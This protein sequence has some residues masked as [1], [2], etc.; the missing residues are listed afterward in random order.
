MQ[1]YRL[2]PSYQITLVILDTQG[3]S[4]PDYSNYML[5][6]SGGYSAYNE[7]GL[8]ARTG[9]IRLVRRMPGLPELFEYN[10]KVGCEIELTYI[11][12]AVTRNFGEPN[13]TF[14]PILKVPVIGKGMVVE[15]I[16][17]SEDNEEIILGISDGITL[18]SGATPSGFVTCV[19][20]PTEEVGKIAYIT[21]IINRVGLDRFTTGV[22][23]DVYAVVLPRITGTILNEVST[24]S[25]ALLGQLFF[26]RNRNLYIDS[27]G[28]LNITGVMSNPVEAYTDIQSDK[29]LKFFKLGDNAALPTDYKIE[30]YSCE[31][32]SQP[33]TVNRSSTDG[34][35]TTTSVDEY[36][37]VLRQIKRKSTTRDRSSPYF[38]T[39]YTEVTE[40]YETSDNG[41]IGGNSDCN[42]YDP[43]RLLSRITTVQQPIGIARA[44]FIAAR[45]QAEAD[46]PSLGT[47]VFSPLSTIIQS[48]TTETWVYDYE[49][50]IDESCEELVILSQPIPITT[51]GATQA[52]GGETFKYTRTVQQD[53][54]SIFPQ[55]GNPRL[56]RDGGATFGWSNAF[57]TTEI[58]KETYTKDLDSKDNTWDYIK[59]VLG[60]RILVEPEVV[61]LQAANDGIPLSTVVVNAL[62]L[63]SNGSAS[64]SNTSPNEPGRYPQRKSRECRPKCFTRRT[65]SNR[66]GLRSPKNTKSLSYPE[67][68]TWRNKLQVSD[69]ITHVDRLDNARHHS[70]SLVGSF[71][72]LSDYVEVPGYVFETV[73]PD[74][75]Q[76]QFGHPVKP[77]GT[78]WVRK[79][80]SLYRMYADSINV[81]ISKDEMYW[82]C[83]GLMDSI[84]G[85]PNSSNPIDPGGG[86]NPTLPPGTFR[87]DDITVLQPREGVVIIDILNTNSNVYYTPE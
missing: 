71:D 81:A 20:D 42:L 46:D 82:G 51:V 54:A 79:D 18:C 49:D 14:E 72:A 27:E 21:S 28:K 58:F 87:A 5:S 33:N 43:G 26:M 45:Q 10:F 85:D 30:T 86:G 13:I 36:D 78:L 41:K 24:S 62:Q 64:E 52:A 2:N 12:D 39:N 29:L 67:Y 32:K 19:T 9:E 7:S 63:I 37:D 40:L 55:A 1:N 48:T 68:Y 15:T 16:T 3:G 59:T 22:H 66:V 17:T 56:G 8:I 25:L 31:N 4:G 47:T 23:P 34:D 83:L 57:V 73:D 11:N 76:K 77:L 53:A 61:E 69:F 50:S 75:L 65:T 80:G 35:I 44:G 6:A 60:I 38:F 70:Y 74:L 84:T